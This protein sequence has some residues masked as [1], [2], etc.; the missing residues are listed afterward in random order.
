[1]EKN[2][3]QDSKIIITRGVNWFKKA[4]EL[5]EIQCEIKKL[6]E[7]E[8]GCMDKL[9]AMSEDQNS[10]HEGIEFKKIEMAGQISYGKIPELKEIDLEPYRGNPYSFWRLYRKY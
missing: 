9:I 1:M 8:K 5:Y 7:K 6:K 2:K 4:L 3:S 10:K